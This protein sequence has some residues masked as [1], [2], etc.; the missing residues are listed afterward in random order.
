MTSADA[1]VGGRATTDPDQ[2]L[3]ARA[4]A[5][6]HANGESTT[7]TIAAVDRLNA[8]LGTRFELLPAWGALTLLDGTTRPLISA[9]APTGVGMR[10][11]AIVMA[12]VERVGDRVGDRRAARAELGAALDRA[13]AAGP[14][15]TGLFVL[16]C[17]IGA[18]ALAVVFGAHD[19]TAVLLAAVSA[20][21]GGLLRR[22]LG[23][24]SVGAIGQVFA[25][26]FLDGTIGGIAVNA[27]LSSSLRLIAVCPA[28]ILVPGP[29][30]LNGTLD[31]LALRI[32]LGF[33]RIGYAA[34]ILLS[35]GSGLAIALALFGTGL[36]VEPA[37]RAVP[38]WLDVLAAGVAAAAYPVYFAMPYRLIAWPV[39]VGALAHGL[40]WW[41]MTY[42]GVNI[43]VGAF[44]ACLL[45][46]IVMS[47]VSA[48]LH[49][50]FAAVAFAAVVSLVPGVY[51][52]RMLDA[53]GSLPFTGTADTLLAA[54]SD[55]TTAALIVLA[56]AVG[57]AIPT[58]SYGRL[59][60]RRKQ[61][62]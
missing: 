34:V 27:D 6:L 30:I 1:R 29:H 21:L 35:I 33:A 8:G 22:G 31:L 50:P 52:F 15:G 38:L 60:L 4:A 17:A 46:G 43:A 9:G 23:R 58:H 62:S 5:L 11:V 20:A 42:W 36:P 59:A 53:L 2:A 18:A 24:L 12:G 41:A 14:A 47:V 3:V 44:L 48:R 37:G 7:V 16:A 57:L 10:A 51:V 39:V 54:V 32:P 61:R 55:G 28:M 49:I 40:R 45:V 25:A 26:A 19:A 13:G 56:M